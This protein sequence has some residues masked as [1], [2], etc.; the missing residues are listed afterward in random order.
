M[1]NLP[2][3]SP[4]HPSVRRVLVLSLLLLGALLLCAARPALSLADACTP[5]VASAVACENTKTGTDPEIWQTTGSGD[6]DLVGFATQMSV[7]KGTTVNFKIKS[8]VGSAYTIDIYRLGYYQGLGARL[9]Q[10]GISH[11]GSGSQPACQT[12]T[13]GLIDCGNWTTSASWAVPSTAVSGV[14]I[15]HLVRNDNGDDSQIPFV[16]RDDASHSKILLQTS[17]ATW[18]AYNTYGGNSLYKCTVACPPGD[19]RAYKAAY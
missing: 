4:A 19:P 2:S 1:F 10:G 9:M 14:Y 13:T 8:L 6:S 12:N 16:V 5:P 7:N 15:A 17:D 3:F 11:T 18:Q